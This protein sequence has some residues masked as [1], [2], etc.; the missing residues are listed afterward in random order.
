[1]TWAFLKYLEFQ[2]SI[3]SLILVYPFDCR[4]PNSP[5]LMQ[6]REFLHRGFIGHCAI[7][8]AILL[9]STMQRPDFLKYTLDESEQSRRR[10]S[11]SSDLCDVPMR[12]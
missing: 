4:S 11:L 7:E 10:N 2:Q 5:P 12:S 8:S 6:G 9:T 3:Q 1:M